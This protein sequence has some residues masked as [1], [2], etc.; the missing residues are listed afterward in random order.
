MDETT[1][2]VTPEAETQPEE[3]EPSLEEILAERDRLKGQLEQFKDIQRKESRLAERERRLTDIDDIKVTVKSLEDNIALLLDN[4]AELLGKPVEEVHPLSHRAQLEKRRAEAE[5][6]KPVEGLSREDTVAAFRVEALITEMGWGDDHPNVQ[7]IKAQPSAEK[8][9]DIARK[10]V[11][12]ERDKQVNET[13]KQHLK[14][15]GVT[16][17][18]SGGPSASSAAWRT[19]PATEKIRRG[20][21]SKK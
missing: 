18:E 6:P 10:L 11:K 3:A 4:Q 13:V 20:V 2:E 7:K 21:E 17:S 12:E 1:E 19:L 16:T 5:T 15:A 8:G 9:L 14:K